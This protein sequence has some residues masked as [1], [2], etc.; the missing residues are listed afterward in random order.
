MH[1]VA[2]VDHRYSAEL[3]MFDYG[4][5]LHLEVARLIAINETREIE[6]N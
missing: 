6:I 5:L 2:V 3:S 1:V 4:K